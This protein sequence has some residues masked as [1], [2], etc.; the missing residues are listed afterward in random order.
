MGSSIPIT[1]AK[2]YIFGLVLM[3]DWSARDIQAWE[4]VPLGPFLSKNFGTTISP[5]VVLV[6]ALEPFLTE[7]LA[8]GNRENLLPYLREECAKNVYNI[9]LSVDLKTKKGNTTRIV[10]TNARNLLYS[11]PQ[12]LTHHSVGGCPMKVGDLLGSGTISGTDT[13]AMGSFLEQSNNG[14][15]PIKLN[16]GEERSFLEDGDEIIIYGICNGSNDGYVGFGEC[17]GKIRL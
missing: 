8:P 15:T 7:G 5:W 11:Y 13:Q 4:Y 6:D 3:N 16:N 1:D 14:K 9:E 2:E 10:K 17:V 12:M